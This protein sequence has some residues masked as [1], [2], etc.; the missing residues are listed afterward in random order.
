MQG[1]PHW[2]KRVMTR[3]RRPL[4][5]MLAAMKD[6]EEEDSDCFVALLRKLITLK[7][8]VYITHAYVVSCITQPAILPSF[9][10]RNNL[11]KSFPTYGKTPL[12]IQAIIWRNEW[13]I[14]ILW[15]YPLKIIFGTQRLY[16]DYWL[17]Y[18]LPV[19]LFQS[20]SKNTIYIH[21][22]VPGFSNRGPALNSLQAKPRLVKSSSG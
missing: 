5:K 8:N 22:P 1:M 10:S 11:Q 20:N 6:H 7:K 19:D 18:L 13:M 2:R 12:K 4:E 14:W 15:W 21:L 9:P 17:P 3:R 16:V